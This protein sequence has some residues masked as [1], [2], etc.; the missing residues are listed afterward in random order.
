MTKKAMGLMRGN[1]EQLRQN[2]ITEPLV[3]HKSSRISNYRNYLSRM[4]T[5][6][7]EKNLQK[8]DGEKHKSKLRK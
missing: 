2:A 5:V 6:L 1:E 7:R 4:T 8:Q 3:L